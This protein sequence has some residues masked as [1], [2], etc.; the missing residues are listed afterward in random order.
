MVLGTFSESRFKKLV[1]EGCDRYTK[2]ETSFDIQVSPKYC[3]DAMD[4]INFMVALTFYLT[5]E[6]QVLLSAPFHITSLRLPPQLFLLAGFSSSWSYS[7]RHDFIQVYFCHFSHLC[8]STL[9]LFFV[10]LPLIFERI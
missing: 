7:S 2:R 3:F 10:H 4:T 9:S 1:N 8:T 5:Q 6:L